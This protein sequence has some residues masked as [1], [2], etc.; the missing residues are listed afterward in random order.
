MKLKQGAFIFFLCV[1]LPLSYMTWARPAVSTEVKTAKRAFAPGEK[2]TYTVSWS[3]IIDAGIAVM[4]VKEGSTTDGRSTYNFVTTTH[5]IGF[6][7]QVFPVRDRVESIV[8]AEGLYSLSF[9][10]QELHGKK[11]RTRKTT[12]DYAKGIAVEVLNQDPPET[13]PTP[14]HVQDALSSLYYVRTLPELTG[15]KTIIVD[16]HDSDKNWSVE[17]QIQGKETVTT[18]AGKFN[19]VK[20]KTY[21]KYEGVFMNKGEIYIWFTDDELRI[22]VRM[23]STIAIGSIVATLTDIQGISKRYD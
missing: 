21:P 7:E 1:A 3:S 19:T 15:G 8:D 23:Q 18:P 22:P 4:E 6:L 12:F 17:V 16:V 11:R 10:L 5:S 9:D 14:T 13:T 20:V 2:L